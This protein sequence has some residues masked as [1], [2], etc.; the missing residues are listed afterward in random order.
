MNNRSISRHTVLIIQT[1]LFPSLHITIFQPPVLF[2][3]KKEGIATGTELMITC[4][5][6]RTLPTKVLF[7][8]QTYARGN[9]FVPLLGLNRRSLFCLLHHQRHGFGG[10]GRAKSQFHKDFWLVYDSTEHSTSWICSSCIRSW[11]FFFL[12][13]RALR[14]IDGTF[15][16]GPKR[17]RKRNTQYKEHFT[18]SETQ[19]PDTKTATSGSGNFEGSTQL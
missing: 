7:L 8:I 3:Y 12:F 1:L 15:F 4:N 10:G 2:Y 6:H 19:M 14:Q 18:V 13:L 9:S 17:R 11:C 5:H 16:P